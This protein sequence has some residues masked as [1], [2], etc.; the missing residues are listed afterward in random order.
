MITTYT[1]VTIDV[2]NTMIGDTKSYLL[3]EQLQTNSIPDKVVT[4]KT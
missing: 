4:R 3:N 1:W 2:K